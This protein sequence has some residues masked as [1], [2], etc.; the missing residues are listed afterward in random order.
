MVRF[1]L[2]P[3]AVFCCLSACTHRLP[4]AGLYKTPAAFRTRYR[5]PILNDDWGCDSDVPS[6]CM[7]GRPLYRLARVSQE[8]CQRGQCLVRGMDQVSGMPFAELI[9]NGTT[10]D[11]SQRIDEEEDDDEDSGPDNSGAEKPP[12]ELGNGNGYYTGWARIV[13]GTVTA[14]HPGGHHKWETGAPLLQ[15]A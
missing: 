7:L 14:E 10:S 9:A 4:C 1:G 5:A 15:I 2:F 12:P 3:T 6:C 8:R 13:S 11:S